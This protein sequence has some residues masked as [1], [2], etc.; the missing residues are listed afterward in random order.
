MFQAARAY[1]A[2]DGRVE[3]SSEDLIK[4]ASLALRARQSAFMTEYFK[5]QQL[6][7]T[8]IQAAIEMLAS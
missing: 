7:E 2:A 1:A 3:V 8:K 4:V 6:E 5:N